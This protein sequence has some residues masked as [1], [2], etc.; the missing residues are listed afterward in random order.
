MAA[1]PDVRSLS[2]AFGLMAARFMEPKLIPVLVDLGYWDDPGIRERLVAL[3]GAGIGLSNFSIE[4]HGRML[5][6]LPPRKANA[7]LKKFPTIRAG[8]TYWQATHHW[9]GLGAGET[10]GANDGR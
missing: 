5:V 6:R 1:D 2:R 7:L 10:A 9:F 3:R 4:G 8:S